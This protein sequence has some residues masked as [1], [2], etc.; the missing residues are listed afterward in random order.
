M[1]YSRAFAPPARISAARRR[2]LRDVLGS[3]RRR[4][5]ARGECRRPTAD[6]RMPRLLSAVHRRPC[7]AAFSGGARPLPVLPGVRARTGGEWQ[8]LQIPVGLA[9]FFRNSSLDRTVAFYPGSGGRNGVRTGSVRLERYSG[10]RPA[11]G[12][13]GRRHR[14]ADRAGARRRRPQPPECHLV[15][16]DA[17]YE[18][19]GRLRMLWHGFD[20]GQQ[21]REFV[22]EFFDSTSRMRRTPE[23]TASEVAARTSEPADRA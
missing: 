11:G 5:P 18:F 14:S 4:A 13:A 9:F 2:A 3:H 20:G 8:L 19:V 16:I 22:D 15:P 6:V 7:L 12:H 23:A 1:T 10:R 21:V 17:C